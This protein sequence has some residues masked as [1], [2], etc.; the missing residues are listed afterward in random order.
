MPDKKGFISLLE[1]VLAQ[2]QQGIRHHGPGSK[3]AGG[4]TGTVN[5]GFCLS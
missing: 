3:I 2:K 1:T 4:F 5:K